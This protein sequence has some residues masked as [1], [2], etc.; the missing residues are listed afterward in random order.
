MGSSSPRS[1]TSPTTPRHRVLSQSTHTTWWRRVRV[2]FRVRLRLELRVRACVPLRDE[3]RTHPDPNP[4]PNPTPAPALTLS[5]A[6]L[7]GRR[8]RYEAARI[9]TKLDG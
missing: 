1:S 8:E 2:W 7:N 6:T 4:N 5:L 9:A 3:A